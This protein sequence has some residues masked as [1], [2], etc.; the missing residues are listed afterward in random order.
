MT[1]HVTSTNPVRSD[2]SPTPSAPRASRAWAGAGVVAGLAGLA[3]FNLSGMIGGV[4]DPELGG[5]AALITDELADQ[6]GLLIAFHTVTMIGAVLSVV[7][8]AGLFRRL[9]ATM[10]ET[11]LAPLIAFSGVF[12]TAVVS[13]LGAGLDT[14]FIFALSDDEGLV[15]PA[16]VTFYNHWIGTIPWLWVLAGL[17][18]LALFVAGRAKAVPRWIG[19]VGLVLGGITLLWGVSPLQYMAGMTGPVWMLVTALGFSFGDRTSGV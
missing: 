16:N 17:S 4:Y 2:L 5:D 14:E 6:T 18:G 7:F 3:T 11:A 15:N 12:G 19:I 8:A 10:G 9:R 13:V 1:T